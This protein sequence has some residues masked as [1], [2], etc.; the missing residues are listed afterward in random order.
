MQKAGHLAPVTAAGV[1]AATALRR[2]RSEHPFHIG[3][4]VLALVVSVVGFAPGLIDPSRRLG[5]VTP[6]VALHG[7]ATFAWLIL[8]LVQVL[9]AATR[10]VVFHRRLGVW[11]A[12]LAG[13]VV[14]SGLVTT[15]E[16][17]RRGQDLS[18]DIVRFNG[19][20]DFVNSMILP[21]TDILV[22]GAFVAAAILARRRPD[23]HKRLML[24]ALIGGL[25]AAPL[26]HIVG[27]FP[28]AG[29]VMLLALGLLVS[30]AVHDMVTRGRVHPVSWMAPVLIFLFLN[31]RRAVLWNSQLWHDA[32]NWWIVAV[33]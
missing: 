13:V 27:H 10:R 19:G 24:F 17:A 4:A 21:F 14:V 7:I 8:Y 23:A 25:I 26:V 22:F 16:A 32:V 20:R 18:G 9:L 5:P 3:I 1:P 11:N 12:G 15:L 6:L 31:V 29:G 28:D 2:R 30:S 33:S